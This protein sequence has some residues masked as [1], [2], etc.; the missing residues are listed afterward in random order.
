MVDKAFNEWEER[1][2]YNWKIDYSFEPLL[3][4]KATE[5]DLKGQSTLDDFI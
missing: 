4:S 5:K 3:H 2:K 1:S